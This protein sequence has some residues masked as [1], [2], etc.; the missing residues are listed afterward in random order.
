MNPWKRILRFSRFWWCK[1]KESIKFIRS[2]ESPVYKSVTELQSGSLAPSQNPFSQLPTTTPEPV[3]PAEEI[4]LVVKTRPPGSRIGTSGDTFLSEKTSFSPPFKGTRNWGQLW[5][6]Q[7]SR[8]KML[9]PKWLLT[10]PLHCVWAVLSPNRLVR[11]G[12]SRRWVNGW[13]RICEAL[14]EVK[15]TRADVPGNTGTEWQNIAWQSKKEMKSE[16]Q[17]AALGSEEKTTLNTKL[18]LNSV[19]LVMGKKTLKYVGFK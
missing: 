15:M 13:M 8:K 16:G 9:K 1:C 19:R 14:W 12:P 6:S 17:Q 5:L 11:G 4:I 10:W 18:E 3:F 2:N 7:H